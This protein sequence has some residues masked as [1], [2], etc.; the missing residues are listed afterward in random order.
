L[1]FLFLIK[2]NIGAGLVV[3][4]GGPLVKYPLPPPVSPPYMVF[5]GVRRGLNP[6][7]E[8]FVK[9]FLE[10]F[11]GKIRFMFPPNYYMVWIYLLI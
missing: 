5:F 8:I 9:K 2:F 6:K 3:I 1:R 11:L 4:P 7:N 10:K